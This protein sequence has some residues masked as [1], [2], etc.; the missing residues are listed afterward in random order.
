[1]ASVFAYAMP[2]SVKLF[3][4]IAFGVAALGSVTLFLL[5]KGRR[6]SLLAFLCLGGIAIGLGSSHLYFDKRYETYLRLVGNEIEAEGIVL[7]RQDSGSFYS[8]LEVSIDSIDG[9]SSRV[10]AEVY[11]DHSTTLQ[12]GDRFLLSGEVIDPKSLIPEKFAEKSLLAEGKLLYLSVAGGERVELLESEKS[13]PRVSLAKFNLRLSY[14]LRNLI[15]GEEGGIAA[16]LLLGNR[17][18]I[19]ERTLLEFRRAGI[20]HLLALSGLHVSILIG[21]AEW[22]LRRLH[23]PKAARSVSIILLSLGY[24]VLTGCS[25]S[26]ARAVLMCCVLYL[27]FFASSQ[28]DPLT[29]LCA[30]L[31]LILTLTPYALLDISLWMSFLAAGSILIFSPTLDAPLKRLREKSKLPSVLYRVLRGIIMAVTVGIVANLGLMLYSALVFGEISYA[32]V[33]ATLVLSVPVTLLLVLTLLLLSLPFLPLL[34]QLCSDLSGIMLSVADFFSDIENVMMPATG[35]GTRLCL[36]LMTAFLVFLA[37]ARLKSLKWAIPLP[38][39]L[40]LTVIV[41]QIT[42][43]SA[44]RTV[45]ISIPAGHGEVRIYS[46][47]G[48]NIVINDTRGNASG[49]YEIKLSATADYCTEVGDLVF[50]RYYNQATYFIS[51]LSSVVQVRRLHL[52][53]PRDAREEAIARRLEQEARLFGVEVSYDAALWLLSLE[54]ALP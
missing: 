33:P 26:A 34:P 29:A 52:P 48:A 10:K 13:D 16:A 3:L 53:K 45:P 19:G 40:A 23:L 20:S 24:L 8:T 49:A 50:C 6:R 43:L 36:A 12:A 25:V 37:V 7:S 47:K 21:F 51:R 11:F 4:C 38:L 27:S 30:V 15:G 44:T 14:R 46:D 1:M 9:E 32:S 35:I 54:G 42:T 17:T 2:S 28:Y 41:T 18:W 31:A 5:K 22:I 39:L